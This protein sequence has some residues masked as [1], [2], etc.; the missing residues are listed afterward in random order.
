MNNMNKLSSRT[1]SKKGEPLPNGLKPHYAKKE[2]WNH[3]LFSKEYQDE[4]F[5]ASNQGDFQLNH[6]RTQ[7]IDAIIMRMKIESPELFRNEALPTA[8][9]ST[10]KNT[11]K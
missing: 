6:A 11:V 10:V 1:I 9:V 5:D 4:L 7:S 2:R 8:L 3:T